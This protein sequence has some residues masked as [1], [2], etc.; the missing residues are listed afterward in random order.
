MTTRIDLKGYLADTNVWAFL[1]SIRLGEGTMDDAGYYRIVGGGTFTDD[2]THPRIR[3]YIPRY[4]VYSTAAGAY[5][6]IFPTWQGLC[7]Q[8]GFTGFTP[9]EQDEMAVALIVGRKAIDE[10]MAGKIE[11]AIALCS[12]EWASL[13]G[14]KAGQRTE[15]LDDV[16][17]VYADNGGTIA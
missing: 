12:A 11:D 4:K 14:S 17:K 2:S 15:A 16:L 5:Q 6:I 10:V 8:Y 3:V 9:Q 7:K 1:K 13:P